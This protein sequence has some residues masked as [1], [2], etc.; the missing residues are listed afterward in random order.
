MG[1][2]AGSGGSITSGPTLSAATSLAMKTSS[3]SNS[4]ACSATSNL[5]LSSSSLFGGPDIL[6]RFSRRA[7]E[8]GA[9]FSEN[10]TELFSQ[11][12]LD[13]GE[14]TGTNG[15]R[16]QEL[17]EHAHQ[18]QA[19]RPRRRPHH[20]PS[21]PGILL[22]RLPERLSSPAAHT[23]RRNRPRNAVARGRVLPE[24]HHRRRRGRRVPGPGSTGGCR[25]R[26]LDRA[27]P[28]PIGAEA[29]SSDAVAAAVAAR[30]RVRGREDADG[31]VHLLQ[32][33]TG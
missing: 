27:E 33:G 18:A 15:Q 11:V 23:G 24:R 6:V 1:R 26:A 12:V 2:V 13:S 9:A 5:Y 7:R 17:L 32:S 4:T 10:E 30:A 21:P 19:H 31:G 14:A 28:I 20:P 3:S 25:P 8:I 29:A 22:L 16:D